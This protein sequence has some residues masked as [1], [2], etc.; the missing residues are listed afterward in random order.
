MLICCLDLAQ[1]SEIWVDKFR[2]D[3]IHT[4]KGPYSGLTCTEDALGIVPNSRSLILIKSNTFYASFV[5]WVE[6]EYTSLRM[7][8]R[9]LVE[10]II[11]SNFGI[12][13]SRT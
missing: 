11:S 1:T 10:F 4:P 3:I 9:E 13:F 2:V 5:V 6:K 8:E 12:V 7:S